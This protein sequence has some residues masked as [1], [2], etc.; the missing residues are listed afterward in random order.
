MTST[1]CAFV[2]DR[3]DNVATLLE[4]A[5]EGQVAL[6]GGGRGHVIA[7]QAIRLGHKIALVD[8]AEREL[9]IKFGVAIGLVT[10]AI[11]AGD[12]VHLHNCRSAV[13]ERSAMLDPQTG[14]PTDVHYE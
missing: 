12:W 5:P 2:V 1:P 10:A 13:D 9:V 3:R 11:K 8:I 4:D 6:T 14:A 7:R